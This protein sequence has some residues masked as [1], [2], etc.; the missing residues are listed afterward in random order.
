MPCIRDWAKLPQRRGISASSAMSRSIATATCTSASARSADA[1]VRPAGAADQEPGARDEIADVHG[2]SATPDGRVL[3]VDRDAHQVL[4]YDTQG[5]RQ[6]ALGMR[7][8]PR[9]AGAIQPSNQRG[10]GAGRRYLC[11]GRLRQLGRPP[12]RRRRHAQAHAGA[13]AARVPGEFTT[14]HA[15]WIDPR[16]RVLVA[17]RENNRVQ[18]FDRD[19]TY[20]HGMGRLLSSHGDLRRRSRT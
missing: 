10:G 17:D 1:G 18:I 6:L 5:K 19:G 7:H 8:A 15:M 14:P 9:A 13:A 20:P 11:R 16:G 3:V 2:V 4:I 12:L